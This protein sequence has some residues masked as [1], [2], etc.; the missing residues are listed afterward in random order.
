M[1][2]D[3][4][5]RLQVRIQ[6]QHALHSPQPGTGKDASLAIVFGRMPVSCADTNIQCTTDDVGPLCKSGTT[7][8]YEWDGSGCAQPLHKLPQ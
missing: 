5:N 4:S 6:S 3:F 1:K 2:I 8:L 7:T